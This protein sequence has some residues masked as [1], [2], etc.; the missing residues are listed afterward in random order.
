M[1]NRE[2]NQRT[3]CS[4]SVA[5]EKENE[6]YSGWKYRLHDER[7]NNSESKDGVSSVVQN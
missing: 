1:K 5:L 6:K 3:Q 2:E 7:K 4:C